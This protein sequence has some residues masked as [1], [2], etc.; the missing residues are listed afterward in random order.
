METMHD[1]FAVKDRIGG[2]CNGFFGRDDYGDK[3]CVFVTDKF[4]V[5]QNDEGVGS[6]LNYQSCLK[7]FTKTDNWKHSLDQ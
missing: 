4:A 1:I 6:V 3:V 7:A 5:F 2:Y